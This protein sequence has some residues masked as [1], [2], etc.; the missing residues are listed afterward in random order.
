MSAAEPSPREE[1]SQLDLTLIRD[2]RDEFNHAYEVI[3]S[4]LFELES[5][6]D[7]KEQ[8]NQLFR[9][10]HSIK[11]NLRMLYLNDLSEFVHSIESVMDLMRNGRLRF[12]HHIGDMFLLSLNRVRDEFESF[13]AGGSGR[14]QEIAAIRDAINAIDGETNL[15]ARILSVMALLDPSFLQT[16]GATNNPKSDDL[17]FFASLVHFVEGRSLSPQRRTERILAMANEMNAAANHIIDPQQ[18]AAAV[19]L[20]DIGMAFMPSDLLKKQG[21]LTEGDRATLHGHAALG[22]QLLGQLDVWSEASQMVEQH[23]ERFD[24][25]GYPGRLSQDMICAGAK[26][27]AIADTFEAMSHARADG[28][29]KRPMLRVVAEVNAHAGGQFDPAWV[30]V[31]NQVVR[32]RYVKTR[33]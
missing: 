13:A 23:H 1:L 31:F 27:I 15:A 5:T 26:I 21:G 30:D 25:T 17:A 2:F 9:T 24:G 12:T 18:L 10:V 20:H 22:A 29:E 3:T 14:P 16:G 33:S 28:R 11:S 8:I 4:A 32:T 19:Y 7:G 6:P